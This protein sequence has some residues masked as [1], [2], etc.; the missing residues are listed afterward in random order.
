MKT[1]EKCGGKEFYASSNGQCKTCKKAARANY[2][3]ENS[4]KVKK[5]PRKLHDAH[6]HSSHLES[7]RIYSH[8]RRAKIRSNGGKL[9]VGLPSKLFVIQRGICAC[10]CQQPLGNNYHIDHRMPLTLGGTNTD[11]NIQLLTS[12]CN[13]KKG[14]QHPVD[15]MQARG[16]LL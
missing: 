9:S 16:F 12:T 7:H 11:D 13:L 2:Y 14:K 4:E 3:S 5:S 15:F 10:G 6:F 1:C 8:N